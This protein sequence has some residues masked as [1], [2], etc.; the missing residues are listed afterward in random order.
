MDKK[1]L[2]A[3]DNKERWAQWVAMDRKDVVMDKVE[4]AAIDKEDNQE[5]VGGALAKSK[6]SNLR[7]LC[8]KEPFFAQ[9]GPGCLPTLLTHTPLR[10][11]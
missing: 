11:W 9:D 10:V 8:Q 4:V 3:I 2:V 1:E 7:H 6:F 5:A